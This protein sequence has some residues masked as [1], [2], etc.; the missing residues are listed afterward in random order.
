MSPPTVPGDGREERTAD[1]DDAADRRD[2]TTR[3][4]DEATEQRD[5]EVDQRDED[6]RAAADDLADSVQRISLQ[7][8]D[9]LGRIEHTTLDQADWPDL[10]PA[11]FARLD[12]YTAEQRRLAGLDRV[13]V[14]ACLDRLHDAVGDLRRDRRAAAGDRRH[15]LGDRH[16][17]GGDRHDS[18]QNRTD[19][20]ADRNQAAIEREQVD[21]RDLCPPPHGPTGADTPPLSYLAARAAR[22]LATSQQRIS[23]ARN[24]LDGIARR[25]TP[26]TTNAADPFPSRKTERTAIARRT[27]SVGAQLVNNR[28]TAPSP[29]GRSRG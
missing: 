11:A 29:G 22:A 24:Y 17:S 20:L 3:A 28:R 16:H 27:R 26:P 12:A 18:G 1:R 25:P 7:I 23:E 4:R 2:D 15:S 21:P 13:A 8:L 5:I 6:A 9:R 19:A 10:T 14:Y